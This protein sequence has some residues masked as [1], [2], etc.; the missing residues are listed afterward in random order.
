MLP[1][2]IMT[3]IGSKGKNPPF[4]PQATKLALLNAQTWPTL[5]NAVETRA[6]AVK[7]VK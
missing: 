7:I 6:S 3:S 5:T 1:W 4:I 2:T